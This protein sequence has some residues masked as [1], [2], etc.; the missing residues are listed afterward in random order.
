MEGPRDNVPQT[1][2][3][4][5][6]SPA[7]AGEDMLRV[8]EESEARLRDLR[9]FTIENQR[10]QKALAER[11]SQL[12]EAEKLV[13]VQRQAVTDL[14]GELSRREQE[15]EQHK[16]E[17]SEERAAVALSLEAARAREGELETQR[18]ALDARG[19]ELSREREAIERDRAAIERRAGELNGQDQAL[20]ARAG[21]LAER[22]KHL[23]EARAS[24]E[25]DRAALEAQVRG[26]EEREQDLAR[27]DE[28]AG[29][30]LA[31]AS[32]RLAEIEQRT[33]A[34]LELETELATREK[35]LADDRALVARKKAELELRAAEVSRREADLS[36]RDRAMSAGA[37]TSTQ[38]SRELERREHDLADREK[39]L[40]ETRAA[41]AELESELAS[42][43][44][45]LKELQAELDRAQSELKAL[46]DQHALDA[47]SLESARQSLESREASQTEELHAQVE[48]AAEGLARAGERIRALEAE[49]ENR[50]ETSA[51]E[52]GPEHAARIAELEAQLALVRVGGGVMP[53]R[54]ERL[55]R[56]RTLVREQN[57]KIQK[58]SDA[59]RGRLEQCE[60]ILAQRAEVIG[61][62]N[63]VR[64]AQARLRKAAAARGTAALLLSVSISI[65]LS[66]AFSWA[67]A[68][69]LTPGMYAARVKLVAENKDRDLTAGE[70]SSWSA[71]HVRMVRDPGFL[72]TTA[73]RM[74]RR[75]MPSLAEPAELLRYVDQR[76][77]AQSA[78][79]GVLT[80][81]LREEG[82]DRA[83]RTL[84]TI[85]AALAS[86]SN[87]TR[88]RRSDGAVTAVS[89]ATEIVA[90][91][92]DQQR[93]VTAGMIFSGMA[94]LLGAGALLF[95]SRLRKA[96]DQFERDASV[97]SVMDADRWP[98]S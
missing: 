9:A 29:R 48:R 96:K 50:A 26:L 90:G 20:T 51:G 61:A 72:N 69:R 85:A 32:T 21:E 38:R 16:A 53:G 33:G 27:K 66:A 60:Q 36:A 57:K 84:D 39:K 94:V 88:D 82:A 12:G 45:S 62:I 6:A 68:G 19:A 34:M 55:S 52:S 37:E 87:A 40:T 42:R 75:G 70:K 97:S 17:L 65:A 64:D 56:A 91:P 11:Q 63:A 73:E 78:E 43:E 15:L 41:L 1:A 24:L 54:R 59:L 35:E 28:Q 83:M 76:L 31:D 7:P 13:G 14:A 80:L 81:E 58:A 98:A 46:R 8:L 93:L 71:D 44:A 5:H 67:L 4:T 77:D 22:E 79:P 18:S 47:A 92:L 2:D 74:R 49:L 30:Q 10:L 86:E 23:T 89:A 95:W 3:T 25:R